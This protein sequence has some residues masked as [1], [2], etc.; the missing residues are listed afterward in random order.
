MEVDRLKRFEKVKGYFA[1]VA[2]WA[3]VSRDDS[4][5]VVDSGDLETQLSCY[6]RCLDELMA[7]PPTPENRDE[8]ATKLAAVWAAVDGV[9]MV[10]DDLAGPMDRLLSALCADDKGDDVRPWTESIS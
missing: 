10:C 2:E 6:S 1:S 4:T 3:P 7:L 8:I 9:K 5:L